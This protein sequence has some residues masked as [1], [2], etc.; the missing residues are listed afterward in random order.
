M[1]PKNL[2]QIVADFFKSEPLE[3]FPDAWQDSIANASLLLN[4]KH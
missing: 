4:F 2:L 3:V 1:N